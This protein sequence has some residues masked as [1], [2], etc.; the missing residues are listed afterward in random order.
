[1]RPYLR[2]LWTNSCQIWCV[3][4]FIIM[5]YWNMVMKMLKYKKENLMTSY[6]K[7]LSIIQRY[8][9]QIRCCICVS[10][11]PTWYELEIIAV[12]S[13]SKLSLLLSASTTISRSLRLRSVPL[14]TP[15]GTTPSRTS[16]ICLQKTKVRF[17]WKAKFT[18]SYF[19]QNQSIEHRS[20]QTILRHHTCKI[21]SA[22][23]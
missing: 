8:P 9:W 16:S 17:R 20:P 12:P 18:N 3:R 5:F 7:T 4:V 15:T 11:T 13:R 19:S 2:P 23:K 22:H 10:L 6:F 14:A 21:I 1:M